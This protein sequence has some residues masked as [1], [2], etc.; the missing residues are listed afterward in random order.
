MKAQVCDN[1]RERNSG[2]NEMTTINTNILLY[3]VTA[4]K[5]LND[6]RFTIEHN[7]HNLGVKKVENI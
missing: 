5:K 4:L 6:S 3:P 1:A 7:S 2:Y